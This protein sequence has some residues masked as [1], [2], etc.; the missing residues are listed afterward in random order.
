[1]NGERV[2]LGSECL[3]L[4]RR[5]NWSDWAALVRAYRAVVPFAQ[6]GSGALGTRAGA[7]Y[8]QWRAPVLLQPPAGRSFPPLTP[9]GGVD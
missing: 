2:A 8:C 4:I 3:S 1:M 6:V 5:R 7:R 9:A